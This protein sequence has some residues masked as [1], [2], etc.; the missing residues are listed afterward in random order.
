M[1]TVYIWTQGTMPGK[2][3][4]ARLIELHEYLAF[5]VNKAS[6]REDSHFESNTVTVTPLF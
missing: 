6:E 3:D 4:E 2:D 1:A 5:A